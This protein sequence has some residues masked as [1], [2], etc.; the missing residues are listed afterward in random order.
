MREIEIETKTESGRDLKRKTDRIIERD[1]IIDT[2][3]VRGRQREKQ[4][5][6]HRQIYR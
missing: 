2:D 6:R 1:R 5:E 4:K 3:N